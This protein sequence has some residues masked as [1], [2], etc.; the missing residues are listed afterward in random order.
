MALAI[1]TPVTGSAITGLTSPTY[2]VTIDQALTPNAMQYAV[3]NI[4]GTQTGVDVSSVDAP[5]TMTL[6]RPLQWKTYRDNKVGAAPAMNRITVV[7]RKNVTTLDAEGNEIKG[8]AYVTT[9]YH[10]V[11]GAQIQDPYKVKALFSA[12]AGLNDQKLI[13]IFDTLVSGTA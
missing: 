11:A 4:G 2:G 8:V 9:T 1:S 5:F 7:V 6:V 10:V 12:S 3:N 13:G